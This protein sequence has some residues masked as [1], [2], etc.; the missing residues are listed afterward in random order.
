M[1]EITIKSI[2]PNY[3]DFSTPSM[4]N[5]VLSCSFVDYIAKINDVAFT[6]NHK[7][8][9]T[10]VDEIKKEILDRLQKDYKTNVYTVPDPPRADALKVISL[11]MR[12][13]C[14]DETQCSLAELLC[15]EL[16]SFEIDYEKGKVIIKKIK[17]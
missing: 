10:S 6:G 11:L 16:I 8:Y 13:L 4:P 2:T 7:T 3:R 9:K 12:R 5:V 15:T 14:V 1:S 17:E